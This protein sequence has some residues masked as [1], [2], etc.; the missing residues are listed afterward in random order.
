MALTKALQ[1]LPRWTSYLQNS[2]I[3]SIVGT[4]RL[5]PQPFYPVSR[6]TQR[7]VSKEVF[8]EERKKQ[9]SW[10]QYLLGYSKEET[11]PTEE[12]LK[13]KEIQAQEEAEF[14]NRVQAC[15]Y[16]KPPEEPGYEFFVEGFNLLM[17]YDNWQ[18]VEALWSLAQSQGHEFDDDLLDKIE[19]YLLEVRERKWFED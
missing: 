3:R 13:K 5:L 12:E 19:D 9:I 6:E 16:K 1:R 17:K 18:G 2:N 4:N 11:G 14:L 15:Y 7:F 10:I 8:E